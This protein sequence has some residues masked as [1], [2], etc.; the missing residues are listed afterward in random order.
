MYN[1]KDPRVV[2]ITPD[3]HVNRGNEQER[4][5]CTWWAHKDT[6]LESV[7]VDGV[8]KRSRLLQ[9]GKTKRAVHATKRADGNKGGRSIKG[10][11][12]KSGEFAG[13]RRFDVK[14]VDN[15]AE[16]CT[17]MVLLRKKLEDDSFK[18]RHNEGRLVF[19]TSINHIY[20][21]NNNNNNDLI[22]VLINFACVHQI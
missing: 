5:A 2:S 12:H 18:S 4:L 9:S 8:G 17:K 15:S 10:L 6:R 11:T 22:E 1:D 16:P 13:E 14:R 20:N 21:N 19:D 3:N 7:V